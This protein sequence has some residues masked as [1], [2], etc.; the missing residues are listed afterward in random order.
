[1]TKQELEQTL[2]TYNDYLD[3]V[4]GVILHVCDD[5]RE[6]EFEPLKLVM[7]ALIEGLGWIYES[8]EELIKCG[9]IDQ[10][11][12]RNFVVLI[13]KMAGMMEQNDLLQVHAILR[14]ELPAVLIKLKI[15]NTA[16]S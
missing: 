1:M 8:A 10:S 13:P 11:A 9:S 4:L 6:N 14:Y 5:L 3:K 12:F 16:V 7:P 2:L 15:V